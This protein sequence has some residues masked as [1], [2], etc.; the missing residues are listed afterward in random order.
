[1]GGSVPAVT[2]LNGH[3]DF[4]G[5]QPAVLTPAGGFAVTDPRSSGLVTTSDITDALSRGLTFDGRIVFSMGC[6][7]GLN[8]PDAFLP[9]SQRGFDW[10]DAFAGART[11]VFVGNTGYGFGDTDLLAYGEDLN[12]RFAQSMVAGA[13]TVGQSL[14]Q[15][16]QDYAGS[17]GV[18]GV[19]DEKTMSELTLYGLPMWKLG[20]GGASVAGAT[21]SG[22]STLATTG[23]AAASTPATVID[24]LVGL[25]AQQLTATPDVASGPRQ[26]GRTGSTEPILSTGPPRSTGLRRGVSR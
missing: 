24:P 19:Y 18:F 11:A 3:A 13:L 14:T 26:T 10:A 9:Q 21:Q 7:A 6:H 22:F 1:M 5:F 12:R 4:Y 23:S 15:A 8:V 2:S 25:T 16:K 20:T 17:L